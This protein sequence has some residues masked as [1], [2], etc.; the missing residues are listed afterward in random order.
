MNNTTYLSIV[1]IKYSDIFFSKCSH[2]HTIGSTKLIAMKR[3]QVTFLNFVYAEKEGDMIRVMCA[4]VC[5]C[6]VQH[7]QCTAIASLNWYVLYVRYCTHFICWWV[8]F[9][10][11]AVVASRECQ[12]IRCKIRCS[13]S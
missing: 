4:C 3:I 5:V 6:P 13:S 7:V 8:F 12:L 2:A 9:T 10:Q 1:L 11:N